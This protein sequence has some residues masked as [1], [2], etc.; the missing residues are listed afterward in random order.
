[1]LSLVFWAGFLF[2]FFSSWASGRVSD[3][4][5]FKFFCFTVFSCV[6]FGLKIVQ[7][8]CC[9]LTVD[10]FGSGSLQCWIVWPLNM[11]KIQLFMHQIKLR[12]AGG[13]SPKKMCVA[14]CF[15]FDFSS[16]CCDHV[17]TSD[18]SYLQFYGSESGFGVMLLK[19]DFV[20]ICLNWLRHCWLSS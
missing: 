1:M 13:S 10:D 3:Q 14:Q 11:C 12:S 20:N 15:V 17:V 8:L 5:F 4:S 2:L 6:G 19:L 18:N 9:L 7:E 16:S